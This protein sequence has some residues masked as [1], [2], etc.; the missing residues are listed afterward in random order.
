V[1]TPRKRYVILQCSLFREPWAR[2]VKLN[3]ASLAG[4]MAERWAADKLRAAEAAHALLSPGDLLNITGLTD[5][6]EQR[7]A[8]KAVASAVTMTVK[9]Q[10]NGFIRV[11]WPKLPIIQGWYALEQG[12]N[13]EAS[14]QEPGEVLPEPCPDPAPSRISDLGSSPRIS[15]LEEKDSDPP[16][17]AV[18]D[19]GSQE[20]PE[21]EPE[22]KVR[23]VMRALTEAPDDLTDEDK[24]ALMVWCQK[25]H[26]DL[27]NRKRLRG[28]VDSCLLWHQSEGKRKRCWLKTCQVWINREAERPSKPVVRGN[29]HAEHRV[30]TADETIRMLEARRLEAQR[31]YEQEHPPD[32]VP[33]GNVLSIVDSIAKGGR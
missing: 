23:K 32:F 1:A 14:G 30:E 7:A 27:A 19:A 21:P 22:P 6:S 17:A 5:A 15:D 31:A 4:H 33:I 13:R 24:L 11:H 26:P 12:S 9:T 8:I 10:G 3:V 25:K 29:G 16:Q 20:P 28:L 18:D 2:E